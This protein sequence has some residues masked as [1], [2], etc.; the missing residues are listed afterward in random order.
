MVSAPL[1]H[2]F[3]PIM[4]YDFRHTAFVNNWNN[5]WNDIFR[6]FMINV[7]INQEPEEVVEV[8]P[9][10]CRYCFEAYYD[11]FISG[12]NCRA[13]VHR[14]CFNRWIRVSN[15]T[16]CEICGIRFNTN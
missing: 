2:F 7:T 13:P 8:E 11:T 1:Q 9:E 4:Q 16:I 6:N 5:S 12:C 3:E 14:G 15:R 10:D